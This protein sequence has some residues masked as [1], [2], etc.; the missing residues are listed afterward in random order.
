[1]VVFAYEKEAKT[2]QGGEQKRSQLYKLF[3]LKNLK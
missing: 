2:R 1:M 3:S